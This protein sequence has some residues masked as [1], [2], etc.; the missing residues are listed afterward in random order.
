MRSARA[1]LLVLAFDVGSSSTR[2]ALFDDHGRQHRETAASVSY[3][4]GYSSDGGAELS[5]FKL[6]QAAE[7]CFRETLR[8]HSASP[9]RKVPLRT[10]AA[11]SFWHSLVGLDQ[12]ARPITPIFTWADSRAKDDAAR[13]RERL[14]EADVHARTGCMLRSTFWPAKILWLKRTQPRVFQ[15]IAVWASP[16]DWVFR[17]LFGTSSSSESMAS[18]TGFYNFAQRTWDAEVCQACDVDPTKLPSISEEGASQQKWRVFNAIGDGAAGNLGSGADRAGIIAIN[19]GTS[20]AARM[21]QL[22]NELA[23]K[24]LPLGLFRYVVDG[25]RTVIGG[26]VSNAG[27]LREWCLREMQLKEA[28]ADRAL[29]RAKAAI[30]SLT[31][32]PFW[33]IERAPTWPERQLGVIDGLN[34]STRSHD[35]LRSTTTAVFYR[36][37][38]IIDLIEAATRRSHRIIVSG[39]IVHSVPA[40]K[41][42]ADAIGRD[43]EIARELEA[44]LRGA[45]LHALNQE[46]IKVS[47]AGGGRV[48]KWDRALTAKH[49]KRR[50][51]Q[52]ELEKILTSSYR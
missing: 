39:G 37:G 18:A 5:P 26:A 14:C 6:R 22:T 52:I 46:G 34:Q 17:G 23:K 50:E 11:S 42:L 27:N 29:S 7:R 16:A 20:A 32:L 13:L 40:I 38:Q 28:D 8:R 35:I 51:R 2:T 25:Q 30:D 49:R 41:L 36:L 9:L 19:V 43:V 33:V 10:I 4:V 24:K 45:A 44:S 15:R 21:V 12:Q 47:A 48:V 3:H 31:V 1:K